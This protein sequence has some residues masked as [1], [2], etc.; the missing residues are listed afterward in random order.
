MFRL[1]IPNSTPLPSK[2][3]QYRAVDECR[4]YE[5]CG[6]ATRAIMTVAF[7]ATNP[8]WI[9]TDRSGFW[10]GRQPGTGAGGRIF[11]I[12]FHG[13]AQGHGCRGTKDSGAKVSH[14]DGRARRKSSLFATGSPPV[15]VPVNPGDPSAGQALQFARNPWPHRRSA[16]PRGRPPVMANR[17]CRPIGS[18]QR[19][20]AIRRHRSEQTVRT[21][22][23]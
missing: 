21:M 9:P 3:R 6:A 5:T 20:C 8:A 18:L 13:M 22:S 16:A 7:G 15:L 17:R 19:T 14:F 2:H 1:Q 11:R 23:A 10:P 12:A 4:Q